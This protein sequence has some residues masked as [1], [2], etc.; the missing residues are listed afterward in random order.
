MSNIYWR[1]RLTLKRFS[2]HFLKIFLHEV[3]LVWKK[4]E[5]FGWKICKQFKCYSYSIYTRLLFSHF[6]STSVYVNENIYLRGCK[7]EKDSFKN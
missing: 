5:W 1:L 4:G 6:F 7:V 2:K 3:Y